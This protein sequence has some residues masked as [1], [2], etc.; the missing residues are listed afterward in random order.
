MKKLTKEDIRDL[1][2]TIGTNHVQRRKSPM[3]VAEDFDTCIQEG[4]TKKQIAEMVLLADDSMV[5]KFLRLL[6]LSSEITHNIVWGKTTD[7]DISFSAATELSKISIEEQESVFKAALENSLT[8]DEVIQIVQ[9]RKRS[10]KDVQTCINE[11]INSRPRIVR[12]YLFIGAIVDNTISAYL[13]KSTQRMRDSILKK[14]MDQ[15]VLEDAEWSGHLGK[16][17]FTLIGDV[18]LSQ[19]MQKLEPDFEQFINKQLKQEMI[20]D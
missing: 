16:K 3:E 14:I 11:I 10:N 2:I 12:K 5:S 15:V 17:R 20:N 1:I 13:E 7:C 4:K 18:Q 8:K 19:E 6:K 9:I